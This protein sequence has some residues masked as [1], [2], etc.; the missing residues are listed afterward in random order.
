MT[1]QNIIISSCTSGYD[2]HYGT[3]CNYGMSAFWYIF[4]WCSISLCICLCCSMMLAM[5]R[6]RRMQMMAHQRNH[7]HAG[8]HGHHGHHDT[9]SSFE[10][11][12]VEGHSMPRN[13]APRNR[14]PAYNAPIGGSAPAY[15]VYA[16]PVIPVQA[17]PIGVRPQVNT[18][19]ETTTIRITLYTGQQATLD[20]NLDHTVADI[21]TYVMSVA[22][23][24]GSY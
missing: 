12:M 14:Q 16:A 6:R 4:M 2:T 18:K 19:K 21:H 13:P 8:H 15:S 1:C 20:L 10:D 9:D 22:P 7:H 11:S 23:T 5:M 24:A 3:C 17:L